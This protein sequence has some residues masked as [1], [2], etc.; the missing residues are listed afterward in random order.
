MASA[1][2]LASDAYFTKRDECINA[3]NENIPDNH[4][5]ICVAR[6]L[7]SNSGAKQFNA[8]PLPEW[9]KLAT[10]AD[11]HEYEILTG[12]VRLYIDLDW[13]HKQLGDKQLDPKQTVQQVLEIISDVLNEHGRTVEGI[14]LSTAS[15]KKGDDYKESFHAVF[16]TDKIF[17]SVKSLKSFMKQFVFPRIPKEFYREDGVSILDEIPYGSFQSFRFLGQSKK[18]SNRPLEAV[19]GWTQN[20]R[21]TPYMFLVGDYVGW[22]TWDPPAPLVTEKPAKSVTISAIPDSDVPIYDTPPGY[23]AEICG[24]IPDSFLDSNDTCFKFI[25]A[26]WKAMPTP[27]GRELI[28]KHYN[29]VEHSKAQSAEDYVDS[30]IARSNGSITMG[31]LNHWAKEANAKA[32][33]AIYA[34]YDLFKRDSTEIVAPK[35][36]LRTTRYAERF[37]QPLDFKDADTIILQ[38]HLGT[39]KTTQTVK[40][41]PEFKRVLIVSGRKT[42]SRFIMGD[43]ADK[44]LPFVSYLDPCF[45]PLSRRDRLVIQVESLWRL[46][47]GFSDYDFVILDESETI[48]NQLFS[49]TTNRHNMIRNHLMLERIVKG[50]RKVLYADAFV[51]RRTLTNAEMLRN[52]AHSHYIINDFNPY[53]RT[54]LQLVGQHT[55]KDGRTIPVPALG[56]F[57]NRIMADLEHK[58]RVV[59]IWSSLTKGKAFVETFLKNSTYNYRFY[60]SES[61]PDHQKELENVADAWSSLDLLMMTTTIT[62]GVNYDPS[63]EKSMFDGIYL[64]GC[65][66]SALPRDIAQCL[67]RCRSIRSNHLTYTIDEKVFQYPISGYDEIRADLEAKRIRQTTE[68]PLIQWAL[69]PKWA[70]ENYIHNS[71][72]VADKV[73]GYNHILKQY[74]VR[75]GY[76]TTSEMFPED[77]DALLKAEVMSY[78][79]IP[80]VDEDERIDIQRRIQHDMATAQEKLIMYKDTMLSALKEGVNGGSV[81]DS[82][83]MDKSKEYK[84]WNIVNEKHKSLEESLS[85][86]ASARFS[87]MTSR[88][89]E[90]RAVLEKVLGVVGMQNSCVGGNVCL[91]DV[92][93][94]MKALEAEI[95]SAFGKESKSHRTK[96]FS[97]SS[98]MDLI[99]MVFDKWNG[100]NM[101]SKDS[102]NR[103]GGKRVRNYT[104][105]IDPQPVWD[106]VSDRKKMDL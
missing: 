82:W 40:I 17:P 42:F 45:G 6:D 9:L 69:A 7:S 80:T 72:E 75:S 90:R 55:T 1:S 100:A 33:R 23:I 73:Y 64:Y 11:R 49:E 97:Q 19:H 54:A 2:T 99:K 18:G 58:K 87:G 91:S 61:G 12:A 34:K 37:V 89:A 13:T 106:L 78:E 24:L 84:F 28:L 15:G 56:E 36:E 51:S 62:V 20:A 32:Y 57:C 26:V 74:L 68:H 76:S 70:E 53:K 35:T 101:S 43:L 60:S 4:N 104:L 5:W 105:T 50:G 52:P 29:R 92:T 88:K 41:I 16:H 71:Q 95:V 30:V 3:L 77:G 10:K 94:P 8:F 103:V 47:D 14:A 63:Q 44:G 27:E 66:S 86:E 83:I 31:T 59:V 25:C 96:E 38:S 22:P 39:G 102:H 21:T 67:M 79:D 46:E 65:A 81:W 48:L 93:E 98:A 85:H